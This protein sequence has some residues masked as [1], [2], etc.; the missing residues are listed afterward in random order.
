MVETSRDWLEKLPFALWAYRT[1]FRTS[2]GATPYLLV[3]GM[4]A[5]LPVEIENGFVEVALEQ[6]IPE[7]DWAQVRFDH[8]IS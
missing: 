6:Q 2:T 8:S 5:V 4:E 3:Y 1:S 7:A